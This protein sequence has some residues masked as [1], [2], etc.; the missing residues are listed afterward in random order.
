MRYNETVIKVENRNI[1]IVEDNDGLREMLVNY[2]SA[3]NGVTSCANLSAAV[4]AVKGCEFDVVLLD[5]VLPD[6]S[7]LKLIENLPDTPVI[8][9]SDLGSDSN[10][11]DGFSQGA[12]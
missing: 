1:L 5:V 9:L 11:L 3:M 12:T 7:G 10:I 8:I 2:F 4:E 6:G